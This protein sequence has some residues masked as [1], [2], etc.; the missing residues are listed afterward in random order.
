MNPVA[1]AW[2][3]KVPTPTRIIPAITRS[4]LDASKGGRP[5]PAR[6]RAPYIVGFV[7]DQAAILPAR[8]VVKKDGVKTK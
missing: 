6:P 7:P 3:E 2:A 5:K 8:G 1:T 4:T